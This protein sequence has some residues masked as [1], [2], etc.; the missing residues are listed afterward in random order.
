MIMKTR[1]VHVTQG[2]G[3]LF[4]YI[5]QIVQKIDREKFEFEIVA[6]ENA[7]C[8][9][10]CEDNFV[11]YTV[12]NFERSFSPYKD[13]SGLIKLYRF[14]KKNKPHLV[15][16]HSAKG[17]FLGRIAAH[18]A[19]VK[20][21]YTPHGISYLGFTGIKRNIFFLLE[22]YAKYYTNYVLACSE[23]ERNRCLY[24][25]G[26]PE[27]KVTVIPNAIEIKE[28]APKFSDN[29]TKLHIGVIARLTYQK[30]PVF[31]VEIANEIK[32][33]YPFAEFSI[34]GAGIHDYLKNHV[35]EKIEEYN[36]TNDFK[37]YEWGSFDSVDNYLKTLDIF[38][39]PSV[40]EGLPFSLLEAMNENLLCI[41]SKC[42]G[43]ADVINNNENGFA[44]MELSDYVKSIQV[45]VN[46]PQLKYSLRDQA[47]KDLH[48]KYDLTKFIYKLENYYT[49]IISGENK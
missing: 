1:I 46:N 35:L 38:L 10:F 21:I 8:R 18:F 22:V 39:M 37:I 4:T 24:E 16:V 43:C 29:Y 48:D 23:S 25:V 3:G 15:H 26:I 5:R 33:L 41:T 11:K 42:D 19:G 6:P 20:S 27:A 49:S 30:N 40:F 7:E 2:F 32:K 13:F 17:G 34:L 28:E 31:F 44:C 9:K 12:I 14:L 45:T 47:K 36:L